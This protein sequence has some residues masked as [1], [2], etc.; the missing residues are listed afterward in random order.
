MADLVDVFAGVGVGVRALAASDLVGH[1]QVDLVAA[2]GRGDRGEADVAMDR[3]ELAFSNREAVNRH[4]VDVQRP[5]ARG[6]A[7][8]NVLDD[9]DVEHGASHG[10]IAVGK[11]LED[12][13]TT[14]DRPEVADLL[15]VDEAGRADDR[16]VV[17]RE[18]VRVGDGERTEGRESPHESDLLH[19][20]A[21]HCVSLNIEP[22][23]GQSGLRDA[24][25]PDFAA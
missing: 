20:S 21:P 10:G 6:A 12:A 2:S 24:A 17:R 14:R 16:R 22:G 18:V 25:L 5:V 11:E 13:V 15:G 9:L 7:V 1:V 4:A 3:A 8:E 19:C 23:G